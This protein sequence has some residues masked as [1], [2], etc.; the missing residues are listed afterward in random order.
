MRSRRCFPP[1]RKLCPCEAER[2]RQ[3]PP[4]QKQEPTEVWPDLKPAP[5][6]DL[7][8]SIMRKLRKMA[9]EFNVSRTHGS[10]PASC[11][12]AARSQPAPIFMYA[13]SGGHFHDESSDG[14]PRRNDVRAGCEEG[15]WRFE[16]EPLTHL[17]APH[18]LSLFTC[19]HCLC[20]A[21][22]ELKA[23]IRGAAAH[24]TDSRHCVSILGVLTPLCA[25]SQATSSRTGLTR[26]SI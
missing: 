14:R 11:R 21:P 20:R 9:D 10:A 4:V 13:L 8:S 23:V 1:P 16:H 22:F 15:Y 25:S 12:F 7:L 24:W 17:N 2:R 26:A 6:N 19:A 3:A 18:F 5:G